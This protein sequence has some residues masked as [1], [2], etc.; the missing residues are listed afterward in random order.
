MSSKLTY[1]Q[2]QTQLI[3]KYEAIPVNTV[4]PHLHHLSQE[5]QSHSIHQPCPL[6]Y[7]KMRQ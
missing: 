4:C 6:S 2:E 5:N 1:N 3:V 7:T